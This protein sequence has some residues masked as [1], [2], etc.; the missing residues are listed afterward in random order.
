MPLEKMPTKC[1]MIK[2]NDLSISEFERRLRKFEIPI[3]VRVYRDK[4][5]ID[6]RTVKDDELS[7]IVDAI[8]YG[9]RELEGVH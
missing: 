1:I 5:F 6:L 9:L 4:V 8:A 3:I 2:L 7:I